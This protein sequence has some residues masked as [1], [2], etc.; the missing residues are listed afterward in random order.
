[1]EVGRW[2]GIR[3]GR[4]PDCRELGRG[5]DRMRE[6]SLVS[7][8]EQAERAFLGSR[9]LLIMDFRLGR[10]ALG[11]AVIAMQGRN[12]MWGCGSGSGRLGSNQSS[13]KGRWGSG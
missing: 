12:V 3:Q 1:M 4:A 5:R 6:K 11:L 7:P 8:R 13:C 10:G 9:K 2:V